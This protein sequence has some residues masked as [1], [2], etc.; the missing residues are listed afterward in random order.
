MRTDTGKVTASVTKVFKKDNL[1]ED[2]EGCV[3][4]EKAAE[5]KQEK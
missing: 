4:K 3:E 1:V 5:A 2:E